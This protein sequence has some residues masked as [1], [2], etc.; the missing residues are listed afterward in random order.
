MIPVVA[1][2]NPVGHPKFPSKWQPPRLDCAGTAGAACNALVSAALAQIVANV[3]GALKGRDPEYLHQLRVGIRRL[4]AVFRI[5][6]KITSNAKPLDRRLRRLLPPLGEARDWDV[7]VARFGRGQAEQR[8]AQARCRKV[9]RG[10]EFKAALAQAQRWAAEHSRVGRAPL[11]AFA[12]KALGRL[13]R[14]ALK[15]GQNIDWRD[16]KRRHA[17]RIAIKRLRYGCDFFAPCFAGSLNYLRSLAKLQDL[18]GELN[19]IAVARRLLGIDDASH[20]RALL[21]RLVPAWSAF[22]KRPCFWMAGK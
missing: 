22:E 18:L 19:D 17:L 13:H 15:R 21:N 10:A 11:T 7:L 5:F 3:A 12:G 6:R 16:A 9:L 2:S 1:G 4:R 14:K 20:E 8:T